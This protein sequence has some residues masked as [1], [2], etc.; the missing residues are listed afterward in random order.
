MRNLKVI[1]RPLFLIN[2]SCLAQRR[3]RWNN[4]AH[5]KLFSGL[6]RLIPVRTGI[7]TELRITLH[8]GQDIFYTR[9]APNLLRLSCKKGIYAHKILPRAGSA[10]LLMFPG[11]LRLNHW[12]LS[13]YCCFLF[14][15]SAVALEQPQTSELILPGKNTLS[16]LSITFEICSHLPAQEMTSPFQ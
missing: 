1:P 8:P 16:I 15:A 13:I 14:P 6:H 7:L 2:S 12:F 10:F 9:A 4:P 5:G 3:Q 11:I